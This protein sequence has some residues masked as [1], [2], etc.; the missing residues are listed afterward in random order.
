MCVCV[1]KM[2]NAVFA[3]IAVYSG[4]NVK[5][6]GTPCGETTAFTVKSGTSH[7]NVCAVCLKG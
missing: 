2:V 1:C 4:T 3:L 6:V 7:G 5:F